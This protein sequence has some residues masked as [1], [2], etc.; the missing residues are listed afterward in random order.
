MSS[1]SILWLISIWNLVKVRWVELMRHCVVH[2]FQI[3]LQ[4]TPVLLFSL[5]HRLTWYMQTITSALPGQRLHPLYTNSTTTQ[6][7]S[8][9]SNSGQT[10]NCK[11][12]QCP[13]SVLQIVAHSR[14]V[15]TSLALS[16]TRQFF[17]T[18][19][20]CIFAASWL[21]FLVTWPWHFERMFSL[22]RWRHSMHF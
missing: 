4:I 22:S 19:W 5:L 13:S 8:Q 11:P 17:A 1:V 14:L 2:T 7:F 21:A 15:L 16:A 20:L 18:S 10:E 3:V 12:F 9:A 6:H